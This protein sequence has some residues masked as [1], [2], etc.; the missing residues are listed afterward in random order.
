MDLCQALGSSRDDGSR[1]RLLALVE[2][3]G[4]TGEEVL[5]LAKSLVLLGHT[6]EVAARLKRVLYELDPKDPARRALQCLLWR[7]Y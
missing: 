5:Y 1:E 7:W 3:P 6:N 2:S 4:I